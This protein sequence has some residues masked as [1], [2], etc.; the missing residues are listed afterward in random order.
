MEY[1]SSIFR[2]PFEP[3]SNS[4]SR[5]TRHIFYIFRISGIASNPLDIFELYFM[6]SL[7]EKIV[8]NQI[9]ISL[10]K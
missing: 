2:T 1:Q 10:A 9:K 5:A 7:Q 6:N 4:N 8:Q 3:L